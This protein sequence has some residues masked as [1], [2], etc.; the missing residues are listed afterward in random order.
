MKNMELGVKYS[1]MISV[2]LKQTQKL[3]KNSS[4]VLHVLYG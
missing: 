2:I 3:N 1:N 4:T